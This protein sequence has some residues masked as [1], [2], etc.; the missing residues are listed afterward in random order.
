MT[1]KPQQPGL[2]IAALHVFT[3]HKKAQLER[4]NSSKPV[5]IEDSG[6]AR[7]H[8]IKVRT[9]RTWWWLEVGITCCH[10]IFYL[11]QCHSSL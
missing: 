4:L 11:F 7:S 5:G 3:Q 10:I 9:S 2:Q 6:N 8:I 1:K